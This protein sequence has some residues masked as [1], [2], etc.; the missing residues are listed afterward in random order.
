MNKL[1]QQAFN[2]A[3]YLPEDLQTEIA[4]QLIN[5]I[6]NEL[7]WQQTLDLPQTPRLDEL[8]EKALQDSINGKTHKKGF[9][10]I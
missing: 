10:Q 1:L 9:D 2:Q 4:T 3:Q 8:A 5:D 7:K 6:E